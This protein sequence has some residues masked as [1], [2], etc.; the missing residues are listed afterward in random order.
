MTLEEFIGLRPKCYSLLFL[1]E[2][3]NNQIIHT[4]VTEKHIAK[5]TKAGVKKA[6]YDIT[7]IK[8]L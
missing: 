8:I 7:I 6:Y 5:G 2:V 1:G 4:D 3:K